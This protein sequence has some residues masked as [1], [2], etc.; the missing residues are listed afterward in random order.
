MTALTVAVNKPAL[1]AYVELYILDCS[2]IG[3]GVFRFTPMTNENA[4]QVVYD[5]ASYT[6]LPIKTEGWEWTSN[7]APPRPTLVVSNVN[8][9]LQGAVQTLGDIVGAKLTRIRTFKQFLDG[10]PGAD[11]NARYPDDVYLIEQKLSHNKNEISW[12]LSSV[13]DRPNLRLPRRQV[14]R[15][16]DFPG[17]AR[18]RRV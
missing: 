15:D 17:V 13:V 5:G 10:Q 1:S 7:G 2:T 11:V 8:K 12:L 16:K 14:L 3:G 6:P 18:V 4:Q 9:F